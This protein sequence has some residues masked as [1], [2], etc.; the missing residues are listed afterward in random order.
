M[1]GKSKWNSQYWNL[2]YWFRR[3]GVVG[4]FRVCEINKRLGRKIREKFSE[5][6]TGERI[7]FKKPTFLMTYEY[8]F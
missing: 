3:L 2:C 1:K 4:S 8:F 6:N 5:F 7:V